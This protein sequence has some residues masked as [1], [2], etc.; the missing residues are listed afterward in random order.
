V[1]DYI[2]S[3]EFEE[4]RA[5]ARR[6]HEEHFKNR[7]RKVAEGRPSTGQVLSESQGISI[8]VQD[9]SGVWR[10]VRSGVSN[11]PQIIVQAMQGAS[12][13]GKRRV[14]AVDHEGRVVDLL[15]GP[16]E[17]TDRL[18]RVRAIIEAARRDDH[19]TVNELVREELTERAI[20][21]IEA[22]RPIV[23]NSIYNCE[24]EE[25]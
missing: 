18:W 6:V 9:R 11:S 20:A 5:E 10:T 15:T 17:E 25:D 12:Q 7:R 2:N 24:D 4:V 14:R 16:F 19:E 8:Q 23:R 3:L 13:N 21:A 1:Q 22:L